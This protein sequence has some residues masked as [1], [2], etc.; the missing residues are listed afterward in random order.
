MQNLEPKQIK[1]REREESVLMQ[2]I[3]AAT[4]ACITLGQRM[5]LLGPEL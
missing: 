2:L 5:P 4:F 3:V 1:Q